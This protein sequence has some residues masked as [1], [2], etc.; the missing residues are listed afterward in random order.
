MN[1]LKQFDS[2]NN[3][4]DYT[5]DLSTASETRIN[6]C[7]T[8]PLHSN[9]GSGLIKNLFFEE[10]FS[11]RYFN[12]SVKQDVEFEWFSQHDTDQVVYKLIYI[13]ETSEGNSLDSKK[14]SAFQ[15]K[16]K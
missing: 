14:H 15:F 10:G 16:S 12:F 1:N 4:I 5:H 11:I 6:D 3:L 2:G 13:L 8:F 9:N 7:N